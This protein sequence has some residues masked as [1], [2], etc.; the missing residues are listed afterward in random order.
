MQVDSAEL[1]PNSKRDCVFLATFSSVQD[2]QK[3]ERTMRAVRMLLPVITV[4]ALLVV[5]CSAGDVG[6]PR[7]TG[8]SPSPAVIPLNVGA[9]ANQQLA[10]ARNATAKYHDFQQA[11]ADGFVEA[12]ACIPGEGIHYRAPDEFPNASLD[13]VFDPEDP[14]VLHYVPKQ[15]GELQLVGV[16]YFVPVSAACGTLTNPPEGFSG[17]ADEWELEVGGTVWALNVWIWQGVPDGVF[18][19]RSDK[20]TCD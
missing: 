14:E 18:A 1:I 17:D 19:F 11:E 12:S 20:I 15:N 13:C 3:K 9:D 6:A 4:C 5:A 7:S 16:E 2:E 8:I 10:A